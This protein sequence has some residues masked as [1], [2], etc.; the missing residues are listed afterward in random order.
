MYAALVLILKKY[1]TFFQ[2]TNQ[3]YF[4]SSKLML[5]CTWPSI[6][7]FLK[8]AALK[9]STYF[10][11]SFR[12]LVFSYL[13][14][15]LFLSSIIQER[16][17]RIQPSYGYG[18]TKFVR[19]LLI[20]LKYHRHSEFCLTRDMDSDLPWR[21]YDRWTIKLLAY[22]GVIINIIIYKTCGS[23]DLTLRCY[24]VLA[25]KNVCNTRTDF[26]RVFAFR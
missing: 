11:N 22:F 25:T 21:S 6:K 4:I 19:K 14:I 9:G 24:V 16:D 23:V 18:A 2:I 5:S 26:E 13:G 15:F 12:T 17:R 3:T 10:G 20:F 1:T 8:F 7:Y